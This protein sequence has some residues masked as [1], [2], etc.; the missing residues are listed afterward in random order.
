MKNLPL[1][2]YGAIY[3]DPAWSYENWSEGGA[4]KNASSHYNCMTIDEIKAL[5]VGHLAS[6]D[7][8]LFLWVTDPLLR[9]GLE[10]MAAWGFEYKTVA[11]TWA[12]KNKSSDSMFFG[13]G[14]WTRA[15]PEMCLLGVNGNP[16]RLDRGVRQ[17]VIEPIREHS[18]KPDR[19]HND[20]ER[21][22]DGPY[23]ELFARQK[24][25]GWTT[26]GNE[27]GKFNITPPP[28]SNGNETPTQRG[29]A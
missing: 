29:T 8:V 21:L 10:V 19:I 12:K 26:W 16:E 18:R 7:C 28:A 17:L 14:Y 24:R 3:A 25:K 2:H 23:L 20:I 11:F 9:E 22:V 13:L 4:H 6:K 1:F 15:N 5:P 27:T